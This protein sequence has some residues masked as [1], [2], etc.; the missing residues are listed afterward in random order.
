MF[1]NSLYDVY[2]FIEEMWKVLV[3]CTD[4]LQGLCCQIDTTADTTAL[5]EG[6][7]LNSHMGT[8]TK[9]RNPGKATHSHLKGS[10]YMQLAYGS[11]SL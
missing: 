6:N 2:P 5:I 8:F 11:H 9:R 4:F 10:S 1:K 7:E 3:V